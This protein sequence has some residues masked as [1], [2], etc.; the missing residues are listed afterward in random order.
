MQHVEPLYVS[1]ARICMWDT[2]MYP[3]CPHGQDVFVGGSR[4]KHCLSSLAMV[5]C[6]Y[7]CVRRWEDHPKGKIQ[8]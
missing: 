5:I 4:R 3:E 1:K 8:T 2:R 7:V 6:V